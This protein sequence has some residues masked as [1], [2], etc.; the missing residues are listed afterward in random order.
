MNHDLYDQT[1]RNEVRFKDNDF[2]YIQDFRT[3][4]WEPDTIKSIIDAQKS[5]IVCT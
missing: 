1:S 5:Y 4:Y 2:M 3:K